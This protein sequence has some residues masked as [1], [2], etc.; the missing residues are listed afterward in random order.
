MFDDCSPEVCAVARGETF[1]CNHQSCR[2]DHVND[3]RS[4]L[5]FIHWRLSAGSGAD[6]TTAQSINIRTN[7]RQQEKEGGVAA[8]VHEILTDFMHRSS[9]LR[10]LKRLMSLWWGF[11]QIG[12]GTRPVKQSAVNVLHVDMETWSCQSDSPFGSTL[13]FHC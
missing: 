3:L 10:S 6:T 11:I 8:G 9:W 12:N 4:F 1:L 7:S 13:Q 5:L 2:L